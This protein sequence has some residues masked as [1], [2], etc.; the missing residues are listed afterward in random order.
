MKILM[1]LCFSLIKDNT[2]KPS[3]QLLVNGA[4]CRTPATNGQ[5]NGMEWNGMEWNGMEWNGM[6]H[7]HPNI[8]AL[9]Q[10]TKNDIHHKPKA[11]NAVN[12][13]ICFPN[14]W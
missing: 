5:R 4:I 7:E 3:W 10:K 12:H 2:R 14:Q 1:Y 6:E 8:K 11:E 9:K 13:R